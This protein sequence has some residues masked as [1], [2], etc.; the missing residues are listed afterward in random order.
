MSK[1]RKGLIAASGVLLVLGE[2]LADGALGSGDLVNLVSAAAV[3]FG[4]YRV[5]NKT[6]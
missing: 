5:P 2:A 4:V 1:Y 3:A 6:A